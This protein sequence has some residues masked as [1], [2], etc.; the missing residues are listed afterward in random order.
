[1]S[2][3]DDLRVFVSAVQ[4]KQSGE[5]LLRAALRLWLY[6]GCLLVELVLHFLLASLDKVG[7]LC[8]CPP[9]NQGY[10]RLGNESG[11][12][13][14]PVGI[15]MPFVYTDRLHHER[16]AEGRKILNSY[17]ILQTLDTGSSGKVKLAVDI[18]T[19]ASY[20][21]HYKPREAPTQRPKNS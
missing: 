3:T 13:P 4:R 7:A 20:V 2:K 14:S 17:L 11:M 12:R 19:R 10:D 15:N 18:N 8:C 21:R 5:S 9:S 6:L 16:D 1:M